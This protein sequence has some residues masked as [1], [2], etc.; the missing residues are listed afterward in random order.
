M[1]Q[2]D[3]WEESLAFAAGATTIPVIPIG[4]FD[5]AKYGRIP[6]SLAKARRIL[7]NF[8]KRVL[9]TDVMVDVDHDMSR[10]AGWV[11]NLRFGTF[12]HAVTGEPI[13]GLLADVEW[14]PYGEE[15]V[16]GKEYRYLSATLGTYHDEESG[17][18][19]GD[20]LFSVSLTN[21]PVM[22]M[23][24]AVATEFAFS[25]TEF[26]EE[27]PAPV[28]DTADEVAAESEQAT[29]S[30]GGTRMA[31][32]ETQAVEEEV[33]PTENVAL[34]ETVAQ[35]DAAMTELAELKAS[36]KAQ[37][38]TQALDTLSDKGMTEPA[39][40]MLQAILENN[41]DTIELS[42]GEDPVDRIDALVAFAEAA[43]LEKVPVETTAQEAVE[44]EEPEVSP[45]RA[46]IKQQLRT[47]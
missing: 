45:E 20:V 24:P 16:L 1:E 33:Q 11:K 19:I 2:H 27:P 46:S 25:E 36:M 29:P 18:D 31:D 23:M 10:S 47:E 8:K 15:L 42:E 5:T 21:A 3:R 37:R 39:R 40:K 26:I 38:I 34:A 22:K 43:L 32:T 13:Q 14:T 12:P 17:E 28:N 7:G 9:K 35:R 44:T 30:E 41:G 4:T 6:L